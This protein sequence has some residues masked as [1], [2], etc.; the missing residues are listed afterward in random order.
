MQV[1]PDN[2]KSLEPKDFEQLIAHL[3]LAC[4]F[5]NV[6][7]FIGGNDEGIDIRGQWQAELPTGHHLVTL[8]AVQCKR[9][10]KSLSRSDIEK[11]IQTAIAPSKDPP[12]I[13]LIATSSYLTAG[14]RRLIERA[15][16]DRTKFGCIF[17]IWDGEDIAN[18]LMQHQDIAEIFFEKQNVIPSDMIILSGGTWVYKKDVAREGVCQCERNTC[19]NSNR[20]IYCY[21]PR[22]LSEW[23]IKKGLYK[24]C[25]DE[26]IVCPR[27][28]K[29]HK[30][31]N[32]GRAGSCDRPYLNQ[33]SQTD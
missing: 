19:V 3:L 8:W 31:G 1:R 5:Q 29:K 33:D 6:Y 22:T 7:R 18:K 26:I 4:G 11:F 13:F 10:T 24:E 12:H 27:C 2:L 17:L 21:F 23:V 15:N 20:K 9:Y 32:V 30:R 16:D 25:F 28:S 14:A